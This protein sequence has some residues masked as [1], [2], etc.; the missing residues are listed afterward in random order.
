MAARARP[1]SRTRGRRLLTDAIGSA[2]TPHAPDRSA[3]RSVSETAAFRVPCMYKYM[4]TCH[5]HA[6]VHVHV[7]VRFS[8]TSFLHTRSHAVLNSHARSRNTYTSTTKVEVIEA[9][10][11][12][13]DGDRYSEPDGGA[14]PGGGPHFGRLGR[15]P[16]PEA[17]ISAPQAKNFGG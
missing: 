10:S 16:L 14:C 15:Q 1:K 9:L 5:V 7:H 11:V 4:S 2:C 17:P 13:W 6:H 12:P 8:Q 3:S